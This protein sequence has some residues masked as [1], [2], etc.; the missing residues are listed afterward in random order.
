MPKLSLQGWARIVFTASLV[1]VAYAMFRPEAPPPV[2][3]QSDKVGHIIGLWLLC[4]S[5]RAAFPR[6]P[7]WLVWPLCLL[8]APGLEYLQQFLQPTRIFSINDVWANGIG[9]L[10]A[11]LS[12]GLFRWFSSRGAKT[13]VSEAMR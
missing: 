3:N 8:L 1:G 11:L 6:L 2:F 5:G 12:W 9:V 13:E 7:F 4:L 10:L